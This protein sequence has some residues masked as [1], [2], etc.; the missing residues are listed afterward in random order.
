[1]NL[2]KKDL[3]VLHEYAGDFLVYKDRLW[4]WRKYGVAGSWYAEVNQYQMGLKAGLRMPMVTKSEKDLINWMAMKAIVPANKACTDIK[5]SA[6]DDWCIAMCPYYDTLLNNL[7]SRNEGYSWH[8][9]YETWSN[10]RRIKRI[11]L[12]IKDCLWY[13]EHYA[14]HKPYSE[15]IEKWIQY[16]WIPVLHYDTPTGKLPDGFWTR[17]WKKLCNLLS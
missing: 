13:D 8:E 14:S 7:C 4:Q 12:V 17:T 16:S 11:C 15:Q 5:I 3:K 2:N 10:G 9:E 6:P 1:M